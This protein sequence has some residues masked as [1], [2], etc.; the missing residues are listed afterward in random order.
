MNCIYY[1]RLIVSCLIRYKNDANL[2][3]IVSF[4]Y[5]YRTM[6]L[7]SHKGDYEG[8]KNALKSIQLTTACKI[9]K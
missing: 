5:I 3:T 6:C 1:I 2:L 9:L 7:S 4:L 8:S